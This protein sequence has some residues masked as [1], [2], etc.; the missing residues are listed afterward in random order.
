V[1]N[2]LDEFYVTA[3]PNLSNLYGATALSQIVP[4]NAERIMG[5]RLKYNF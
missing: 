5:V 3:L 2:A 1:N 4:R